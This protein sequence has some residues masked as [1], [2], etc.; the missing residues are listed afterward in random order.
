MAAARA[1]KTL[2]T[3]QM[4]ADSYER[5]RQC[6]RD[7]EREAL[8]AIAEAD[9]LRATLRELLTP[10]PLDAWHED[11]GSA[12]WWKFPVVEAPYSGSPLDDEWPGYHTHW[13]PL[14]EVASPVGQCTQ[15]GTDKP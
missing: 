11:I 3:V 6:I 9:E 14:P 2:M 12:L 15:S 4:P 5:M 7:R 13:T 10:Q 8:E 1:Q